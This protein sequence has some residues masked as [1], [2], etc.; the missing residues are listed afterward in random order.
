LDGANLGAE[1]TATIYTLTWNTTTVP[2]G[3]H[4][5]TAVARDGAGNTTTSAT[6]TVTVSNA[7][8]QPL[9]AIMFQASTDHNIVTSYLLDV[10]ANGADPNSA[11]PVA[12]SNLAKGT[13]DANGDITV[14]RATF[15]AALAPGTYLMTVSSLG[16]GGPTRSVAITVV[17]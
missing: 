10:F 16:T 9:T 17:R 8:I 13:P 5:L 1:D 4:T 14:N 3:T 15:F 6:V 12:S 2:N 11:T 7:A